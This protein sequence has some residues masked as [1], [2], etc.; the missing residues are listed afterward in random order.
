MRRFRSRLHPQSPGTTLNRSLLLATVVSL[1]LGSASCQGTGYFADRTNDF[2]D[3]FTLVGTAGPEL[4]AGFHA[5]DLAHVSVGGG[6]HGEAGLIGRKAGV[7]TVATYGLPFVPFLEGGILHGRYVFTEIGGQWK[8]DD[9]MDECY[10]IHVIDAGHTSPE[11]DP[12]RAFDLE[13]SATVLV[14]ARV[15]F[16]PGEFVDFLAG[17]VG[18]DPRADDSKTRRLA[19]AA[20]QAPGE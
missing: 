2:A 9:V 16:S 8:E 17:L 7:A 1:A 5:T 20:Q 4:S 19:E 10:L 14:G 12:W 11:V 3:S 18:L 13:V 15:G 6:F